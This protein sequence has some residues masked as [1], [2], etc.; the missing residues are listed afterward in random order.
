MAD[1]GLP[2]AP[3]NKHADPYD[4]AGS[5]SLIG[6]LGEN[7]PCFVNP[8]SKSTRLN[9]WS[10]NNEV[11]MLYL[12]QPVQTGLS[13]NTRHNI[14]VNLID[15]HV[16]KLN[17][18][19]PIPQQNA[20]FHVGTRADNDNT[21][22]AFGSVAA[23]AAMWH[24]AQAF[25]QEFPK[26]SPADN[27]ISLAAESYGGR[28]GPNFFTFF[29]EQNER[30]R[31]GT[32]KVEGETYILHLDSLV[33]VSGC[34]D[35]L[36]WNSYSKIAYNNTYGIKAINESTRD[37]ILHDLT[38]KRGCLDQTYKCGNLSMKYDPKNIGINDTVN[39][40]CA[41]ASNFCNKYVQGPYTETGRN[42]YDI[43]AFDP[44]SFTP[45]F[46]EGY[47]NQPF[48]QEALGVPVNVSFT[49][50]SESLSPCPRATL[51]LVFD[52]SGRGAA[53]QSGKPLGRSGTF[54]DQ[55]TSTN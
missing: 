48:V 35:N 55:D 17:K 1:V 45:P 24:F 3:S 38:R 49:P 53:L 16:T 22:T 47:L 14:T 41:N 46:Y 19:D 15:G 9:E 8:D 33:L 50:G 12:D 23:A 39:Q 31:N 30:I 43:T 40:V 10:W 13:Y 27:R 11:N 6:L 26:Y 21:T 52:I 51:T 32:W 5:S 28:Y 34:I 37:Q 42:F 25:F 4:T 7:G 44:V 54:R 20:T 36:M 18:T 2:D 29:E